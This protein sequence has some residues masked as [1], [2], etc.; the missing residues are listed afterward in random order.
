MANLQETPTW[1]AGIYQ[2]ETS[3]PVMGGENG[4]DNRAPR[5][6]ANRTLWLK[7]ELAR[8]IDSVNQ[9]SN[10][11]SIHKADKSLQF[12]AG[13]GLTGGGDLS[14]HRTLSLGTPSKITATST[15]VAVSNTHSHEIDKASTT[16]QGI[17]QLNDTLTSTAINQALTANQ[18]KRLNDSKFDKVGGTITGHVL[19]NYQNDWVGYGANNPTEGKNVFFDGA[20]N[21]I[22]RGG[23]QIVSRGGG[24]YDTVLT[25]TPEGVTNA[26]RRIA[27]LT[28]SRDGLH[29]HA[30]G[31]LHEYFVKTRDNQTIDGL[32]S[33]SSSITVGSH[34]N[35]GRVTFPLP[36]N[37]NWVV[38]TN[39]QYKSLGVGQPA[40]RFNHND[41]GNRIFY[42]L[43]KSNKSEN[44]AYQ[45]WT[46]DHFVAHDEVVNNL[47]STD[48]NKPLSALQGKVLNEQKFDKAGGVLTGTLYAANSGVKA[49]SD[50]DTG[51][52]WVRD[53]VMRVIA[54]GRERI[55]IA[56]GGTSLRTQDGISLTLQNDK[57]LVVYDE[58]NHPVFASNT[59]LSDLAGKVNKAGDTMTGHLVVTYNS[60]WV[61]MS[62]K[63][64]NNQRNG[65]YDVN[66]GGVTRG[67][68]QIVHGGNNAYNA[69]INITSQGDN[70]ERRIAGLTVSATGLHAHAY[71]HLHEYFVKT[72]DNQTIGGI[73]NFTNEAHFNSANAIRLKPTGANRSVFF[74]FDGNTFYL[75]KTNANDPDGIWDDARPLEWNVNT[76]QLVMRGNSDTASRLQ[77][78]RTIALTGAVTGSIN[79]DGSQNVSLT[80]T[81]QSVGE[82]I[83]VMTGT[84]SHGGTI[85]L[86]AGFSENQCKWF[87]S[88]ADFETTPHVANNQGD[89]I[90]A[91]RCS[92]SGR[93]VTAQ[94][95]MVNSSRG[96][97]ES[98]W[99]NISANY[100]IIGVK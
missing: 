74:R 4:I 18:G 36:D 82:K 22:N 99:K 88:P 78:P 80:T 56:H 76:N 30:Y 14:T 41:G 7:N 73:K 61:G 24:K 85:P 44:I 93:V 51:I 79:F 87:V 12:T 75:L 72:R 71:G 77:I 19:L 66:I 59:V 35:W 95:V 84:V 6:L 31:H 48:A 15:N 47:T 46:S 28:V 20:V 3:D 43:V 90:F 2:L 26:D 89:D 49:A 25:V 32:K 16:T 9:N 97:L 67:S 1:E 58:Q 23:I 92:T 60:D 98:M 40:F 55:H 63:N 64:P 34:N 81:I 10:Y 27:G 94:V 17:V 11:I 38:E 54:D 70:A 33:F 91:V 37:T 100:I 69:I 8:Q 62:V 5:Q 21:G 68:F 29:A 86:P 13:N 57:N 50:N 39:P 42:D 53:G 96:R 65:F 52:E 45:S 83:A